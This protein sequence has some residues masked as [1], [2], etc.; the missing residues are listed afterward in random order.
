MDTTRVKDVMSAI[1]HVI[2]PDATLREAAEAMEQHECG[3]LPVCREDKL[4]G[5]LTDRDIVVFGLAG[6]KNPDRAVVG[7]IM[8]PQVF[9]C[10]EEDTLAQ[11]A[12]MMSDQ[13]VRRLVVVDNSGKITGVIS[14]T[15]MI[16]CVDRDEV[17][18]EIMH[19]LF[20]YA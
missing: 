6:G 10:K 3:S 9:T 8:A 20:R 7:E 2:S 15:D 11:V 4:V 12:D 13:D 19:H 1:P 5:I 16:K 17:N 14:V 18:D